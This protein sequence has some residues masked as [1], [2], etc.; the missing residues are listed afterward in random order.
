MN[1]KKEPIHHDPSGQSYEEDHY[2]QRA[3]THLLSGIG[4]PQFAASSFGFGTRQ[5]S[6]SWQCAPLVSNSPAKEVFRLQT[7]F[8]PNLSMPAV[9]REAEEDWEQFRAVIG[10]PIGTAA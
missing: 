6:S 2:A 1:D 8:R 7:V 9:K 10:I 5:F 4:R 3:I